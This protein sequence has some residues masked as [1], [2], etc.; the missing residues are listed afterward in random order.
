MRCQPVQSMPKDRIVGGVVL[1]QFRRAQKGRFGAPLPR[2]RRDFFV[3]RGNNHA[4]NRLGAQSGGNAP[5]NQGSPPEIADVLTRNAL[6]T[7]AGRDECQ[8]FRLFYHAVQPPSTTRLLPVIYE[9]A[10]E[11]KKSIAALISSR[12]AILPKMVLAE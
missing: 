11:A 1:R 2:H 7:A 6:G 5:G 4:R 12:F 3:I 9:D 10:S 8:H